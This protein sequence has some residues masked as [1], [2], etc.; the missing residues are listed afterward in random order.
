MVNKKLPPASVSE[1]SAWGKI[2]ILLSLI[3]CV[4]SWPMIIILVNMVLFVHVHLYNLW[5]ILCKI[6]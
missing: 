5:E 4:Y 6:R 2:I 3:A 1:K